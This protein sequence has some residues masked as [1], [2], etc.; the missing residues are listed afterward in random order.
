MAPRVVSASWC[1]CVLAAAGCRAAAAPSVAVPPLPTPPIA[2]P[3]TDVTAEFQVPD[4]LEVRVWAATPQLYNPTD[5]DVDGRG[6]VW[7]AEG[8][9]YREPSRRSTPG[10]GYVHRARDRVVVLEDADGDGAADRSTVFAED[11]DL[12][13]PLGIAVVGDRAI[14]SCS[15]SALVYTDSDGDGRADRKETLLT[16]FGGVDSDHGLHAFVEGPDGRLYFAAGNGGKIDVTDRS[17]HRVRRLPF[18]VPRDLP[19]GE[20][21][22]VQ[23]LALR[24]NPDGTGLE[25][26]AHDFRNNYELAVDAFGDV[27]QNDNDDDGH[28]SCRFTHVLEGGSYG[29]H[30]L[31]G[32]RTWFADR[33]PGQTKEAAHWHLDDP[34]T[35]P[36]T[37]ITGSGGPTGL[38]VYERGALP[39]AYDGMILNADAGRSTVFAH[40]VTPDGAG[41][42]S[43]RIDFIKPRAGTGDRGRWFRPSDVAVGPDGAIYVA[44]WYDPVVGGAGMLDGKAAGRI[45]RIAPR[46]ARLAV[47]RLDLASNAGR[48]AALANPAVHVRA[49]AADALRAA[50]PA[51]LPALKPALEARG[52]LALRARALW[53]AAALG[54]EGRALVEAA[55]RDPEPRLRITALRALRQRGEAKAALRLLARDP[56]A[57]VRREVAVALRARPSAEA[58]PLLVQ[59]ARSY[60]GGDRT[61]LEA[62]GVG[63]AGREDALYRAVV[64]A[65]DARRWPAR[66]AELAFRLHPAASVPALRARLADRALPEA[67]RQQALV[68]LAFVKDRQAAGAVLGV[69][70]SPTDPLARDALVLAL[71]RVDGDWRGFGLLE[72]A[73][74]LQERAPAPAG[75]APAEA[76]EV[77]DVPPPE[78]YPSPAQVLALPGDAARGRRVFFSVNASCARCHEHAGQGG[79]V[80]P[81]LTHIGGKLGREALLDAILH[82]SAAIAYGYEATGVETK[83]GQSYSGLLL[84]E[85]DNVVLKEGSGELRLIPG[86]E[87]KA[88]ARQNVSLMPD[89]LAFGLAP[90]QLRDLVEFL[91]QSAAP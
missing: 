50:G 49:A 87:I 57:A 63:A 90:A 86:A 59:L 71:P 80:G 39:A 20:P 1:A 81:P 46:G 6:R 75:A 15:P 51:A 26:L 47:P 19:P 4:G 88:R 66:A 60:A 43:R 44:D 24:V 82:P 45:L 35:A 42:R 28:E 55:L 7:V 61:L 25:V 14:V 3:G 68:A 17:G 22:W 32:R 74:A 58:L 72:R 10:D 48:V 8:V 34:G 78:R 62:I 30:S 9:R 12:L 67:A 21:R 56:D 79:E 41:F 29:F 89:G 33:R 11:A 40:F 83:G 23:G 36:T 27:W 73:L 77:R 70:E 16:G 91:A 38:A 54:P 2:A 37:E 85:G 53:V 65:G 64:P 69:A 52:D 31:D 13:V 18:P 5:I 76:L 84:A